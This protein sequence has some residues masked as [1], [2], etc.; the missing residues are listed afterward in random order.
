MQGC[1]KEAEGGKK[2]LSCEENFLQICVFWV[3]S[4]IRKLLNKPTAILS[5]EELIITQ[6][7]TLLITGWAGPNVCLPWSLEQTRVMLLGARGACVSSG[8]WSTQL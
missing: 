2:L 5:A 4:C 6:Q 7:H 1:E 8:L 3:F